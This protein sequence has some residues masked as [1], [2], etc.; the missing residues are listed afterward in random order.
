MKFVYLAVLSLLVALLPTSSAIPKFKQ[1]LD[2]LY[3][4]RTTSFYCA[5]TDRCLPRRSTQ[6]PASQ[7]I[8]NEALCAE[9][10]QKCTNVTFT[11]YSV[12]TSQQYSFG[13]PPGSGCYITINRE[14]M[15][16]FGTM[17]F[18]YE[19][20]NFRVFDKLDTTYSSGK[21]LGLPITDAGWGERKVFIVNTGNFAD[22]FSV[23]FNLGL[24]QKVSYSVLIGA[25]SLTY[26]LF[27]F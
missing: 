10:F 7:M 19:N 6:C 12:G 9:S 25:L 1:C 21:L 17:K 5:S 22:G 27:D 16:S 18:K 26:M 14:R 2:C 11:K 23:E 13:L 4:N 24:L 3:T 8:S 20:P 15:G